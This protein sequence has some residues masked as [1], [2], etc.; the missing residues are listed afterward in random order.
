MREL[1]KRKPNRLKNYDYSQN[2]AYFITV[3][4]KNRE[5]MFWKSDTVGAISNRPKN[6]NNQCPQLSEYGKFAETAIKQ[7]DDRIHVDCYVIMPNHIHMIIVIAESGR[8]EF[9]PTVVPSN[10]R[11]EFAPTIPSIVRYIKSYVTKRIGFSPWQKSFHDRIVRNEQ[12]YYKIT[13]Y[14]ENNPSKWEE[15]C[16]YEV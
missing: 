7:L 3:C 2:G 9:A 6:D 4:T 8:T 13:E 16:F 11:T 15:D 14:I 1:P 5:Q 12:E 10:G